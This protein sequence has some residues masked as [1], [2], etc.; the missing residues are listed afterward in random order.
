[1]GNKAKA[2]AVLRQFERDGFISPESEALAEFGDWDRLTA[3]ARLL[4]TALQLEVADRRTDG[5]SAE[6]ITTD[7]G[8]A[9][10]RDTAADIVAALLGD[11]AVLVRTERRGTITPQAVL[12]ML[13]AA[14]KDRAYSEREFGE[15]LGFAEEAVAGAR[16][17][18]AAGPGSGPWDIGDPKGPPLTQYT[19]LGGIQVPYQPDVELRPVPGKD[20]DGVVHAVNVIGDG[21]ALQLQA[22]HGAEDY[23]WDDVRADLMAKLRE[24]GSPVGEW[25]GAA[26]VELRAEMR[27][28]RSDGSEA[29]LNRRFLGFDGP[30]WLLRGVVTGEGAAPDSPDLWAHEFF[31]H[32]VVN[33]GFTPFE[34]GGPIRLRMP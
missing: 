33:P 29:R 10:S 16:Q 20:G 2:T 4:L 24:R 23:R 31:T 11:V 30:G 21:T 14:I 17:V 19:D 13:S 15:L 6:R 1:V 22:Y 18:I 25:V 32:T 34:A 7:L 9:L 5:H 12:T 28:V 27:V 8:S 26:G 3:P